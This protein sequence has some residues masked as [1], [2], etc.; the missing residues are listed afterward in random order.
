MRL[1]V[2]GVTYIS[3]K[4]SQDYRW[5]LSQTVPASCGAIVEVVLD[6]F[7]FFCLTLHDLLLYL[8]TPEYVALSFQCIVLLVR[9]GLLGVREYLSLL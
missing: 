7:Y 2:N 5:S 1:G 8:D 9:C 3:E 4:H 6:G